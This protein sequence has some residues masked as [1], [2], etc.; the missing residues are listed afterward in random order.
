MCGANAGCQSVEV[1]ATPPNDGD[2]GQVVCRIPGISSTYYSPDEA[3]GRAEIWHAYGHTK[4]AAR[5]RAA[6]TKAERQPVSRARVAIGLGAMII[7]VAGGWF[8]L[9]REP[10]TTPLPPPAPVRPKR[11]GRVR[12]AYWAVAA[13]L[14]VAA[15]A[16]IGAHIAGEG[17]ALPERVPSATTTPA[18][19]VS[20]R[21]GP[22]PAA[23]VREYY[24]AINN[25]NF[26]K[27]WALGGKNLGQSFTAFVA[28]FAQDAN[29]GIMSLTSSGNTVTARAKEVGID[30]ATEV[31][32]TLIY[33]LGAEQGQLGVAAAGSMVLFLAI[34]AVTIAVNTWRRR[35]SVR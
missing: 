12:L 29:I 1:N 14:I 25:D 4:L 22:D 2:G 34:A 31:I 30:G 3:R 13:V 26:A 33:K 35:V 5:L 8:V 7:V 18:K 27:A 15:G 28:Q 11:K 24:K 17:S 6:A 21:A 20:S 10:A 32:M 16:V 23:V 19:S 9:V